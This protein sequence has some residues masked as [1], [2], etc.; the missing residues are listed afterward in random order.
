MTRERDF[1]RLARAWLELGPDEAPDRVVAAVL[2]AAQTT[3]QTRRPTRWPIWRSFDMTRLPIIATTAVA[4]LVVLA[5][6]GLILNR[7]SAGPARPD[8][9]SQPVTDRHPIVESP[10]DRRRRNTVAGRPGRRLAGAPT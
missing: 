4:V 9:D 8:R 7:G 1:D 6:G 10:R 2:Q 5:G 3:P